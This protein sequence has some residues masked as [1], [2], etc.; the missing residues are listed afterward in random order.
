MITFHTTGKIDKAKGI[1]VS[2]STLTSIHDNSISDGGSLKKS[3]LKNLNIHKWSVSRLAWMSNQLLVTRTYGKMKPFTQFQTT[4][5]KAFPVMGEVCP[6]RKNGAPIAMKNYYT[7]DVYY[8]SLHQTKIDKVCGLPYNFELFF[9]FGK[10][11][12]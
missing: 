7:G 9:F 6:A 3:I 11:Y 12:L 1:L 2:W 8:D 4:W 5:T 10:T